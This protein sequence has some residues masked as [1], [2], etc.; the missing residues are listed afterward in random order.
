MGNRRWG[1]KEKRGKGESLPRH[2][3]N[4]DF[5]SMRPVCPNLPRNPSKPEFTIPSQPPENWRR[6]ESTPT[7][8]QL[9]INRDAGNGFLIHATWMSEPTSPQ[10]QIQD[11]AVGLKPTLVAGDSGMGEKKRRRDVSQFTLQSPI[12]HQV[13]TGC[14]PRYDD[15]APMPWR[16]DYPAFRAWVLSGVFIFT[17]QHLTGLLPDKHA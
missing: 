13:V 1:E 17:G 10:S 8:R 15:F 2:I 12:P 5:E 6:R 14:K 7:Y 11:R 3:A 16:G 4:M 9:P